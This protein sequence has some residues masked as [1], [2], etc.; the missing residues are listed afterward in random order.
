MKNLENIS[1][2]QNRDYYLKKQED[3]KNFLS[4]KEKLENEFN[5]KMMKKK[6]KIMKKVK[7]MIIN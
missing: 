6:M 3:E 7:K 4:E 5:L 1:K 2:K